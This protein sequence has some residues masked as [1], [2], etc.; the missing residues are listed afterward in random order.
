M[1]EQKLREFEEKF[2]YVANF[3]N[4]PIIEDIEGFWLDVIEELQAQHK[5]EMKS[6]HTRLVT[7]EAKIALKEPM[8]N[9]F[10][11][12]DDLAQSLNTGEKES[13]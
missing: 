1:I 13:I 7:V 5:K 12:I 2:A 6:I 9:I 10:N 8:D 3:T 4:D 11:A